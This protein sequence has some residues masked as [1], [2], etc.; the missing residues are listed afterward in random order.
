MVPPTR[1]AAGDGGVSAAGLLAVDQN[2]ALRPSFA[3]I[4]APFSTYLSI[5][6][7]RLESHVCINK[8]LL[9]QITVCDRVTFKL[10]NNW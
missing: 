7:W 3:Y 8:H 10:R 4:E 9:G 2:R 6:L 5:A 1:D